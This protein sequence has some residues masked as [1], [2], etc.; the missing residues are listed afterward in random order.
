MAANYSEKVMEHF[1]NPRNVGE[2]ENPDGVGKVGNPTCGDIMEMYI[3]VKDNV[4]TDVKFKTFG[5]GAAI[6]T[7]SMST[8]MIKGKT[9]EE[10]LKLSNR[11]VADALGGLPPVKMHCS[12]LAEEAV[13]AAIDDY[14]KKT[15]GK[16]LPGFKPSDGPICEH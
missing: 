7:S 2:M 13:K 10:A 5:C 6:A 1:R 15:T 4:I 3:K 8:E 14:L 16:G 11:A 12:V 9:I